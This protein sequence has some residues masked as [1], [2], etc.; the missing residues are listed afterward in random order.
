MTLSDILFI[1]EPYLTNF[2]VTVIIVW[3]GY[4][5]VSRKYLR[6]MNKMKSE[7]EQIKI[8]NQKLLT[9]IQQINF[10]IAKDKMEKAILFSKMKKDF[11]VSIGFINEK[12]TLFNKNISK[13]NKT[14]LQTLRDEI[15]LM[16][17]RNIILT[18]NEICMSMDYF[19][20]KDFERRNDFILD[21]ILPTLEV[22]QTY[23]AIIND[24]WVLQKTNSEKSIIH[25]HEFQSLKRFLLNSEDNANKAKGLE[26]ILNITT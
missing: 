12:L 14:Q 19:L 1:F 3:I 5:A 8:Q 11:F 4:I 20:E 10:S 26:I 17:F 25:S 2:S 6:E 23:F 15:D 13:S 21:T 24:D 16:V 7:I 22:L 9:E 18:I